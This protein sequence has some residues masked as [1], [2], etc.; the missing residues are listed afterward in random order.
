MN[1]LDRI[2]IGL[3]RRR[4]VRCGGFGLEGPPCDTCPNDETCPIFRS[5]TRIRMR[6][7]K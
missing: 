4:E 7:G 2:R 3:I 5:E 1:L 6:E